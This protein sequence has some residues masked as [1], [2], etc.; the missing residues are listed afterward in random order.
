MLYHALDEEWEGTTRV[1]LLLRAEG[2]IFDEVVVTVVGR[3]TPVDD[4][5]IQLSMIEQQ[6]LIEDGESIF[7]NYEDYFFDPEQQP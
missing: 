1:E 3:I 5:I 2:E 6:T 7:I 4:Q